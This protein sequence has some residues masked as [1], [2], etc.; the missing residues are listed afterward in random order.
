LRAQVEQDPGVHQ[1][2][3]QAAVQE[4]RRQQAPPFA[5]PDCGTV[6]GAEIDQRP[7][8]EI[9][10]RAASARAHRVQRHRDVKAGVDQQDHHRRETGVR[11]QAPQYIRRGAALDGGRAHLN[12]AIGA[13]FIAGRDKG[14]AIRAH[15][16][17]FH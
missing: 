2:V 10:H 3:Q 6:L 8:I 1:D 5:R 12:F 17:G 9:R 16:A 7:Q 4:P 11:D 14:P 15:P 13:D